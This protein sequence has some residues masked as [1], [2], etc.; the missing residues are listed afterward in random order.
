MT[1]IPTST[2]VLATAPSAGPTPAFAVAVIEL[3]GPDEARM[4]ASDLAA[5]A[6]A[7][8]IPVRIVFRCGAADSVPQRRRRAAEEAFEETGAPIV[9]LVEDTT[10]LAPG[11][12][13]ALRI[14]FADVRVAAAGGPVQVAARLPPRYRALGRLEYGLFDGTRPDSHLPGNA[15]ALRLTDLRQAL[16]PGEGIVEHDLEQRFTARGRQV[17]STDALTSI[18]ALPDRYG[19]RLSTRFG[20]GR[21]YGAG[22]DGNRVLG[23]L[24]ALLAMPVLSLRGF[25]AARAAVQARQWLPELPWIVAM[26]TAWALGELTGQV[27]GRGKSEGSWA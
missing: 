12:A 22:R 19:A 8:A 21:L 20:H 7:A 9:L 3:L 5:E 1:K 10:C 25:R 2:A 18:Y 4:R 17:R 6:E 13:D 26:S 24:R 16:A 11:W 23:V 15:F 14:T 27:A